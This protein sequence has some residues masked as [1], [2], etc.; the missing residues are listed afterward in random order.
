MKALIADC[1]T[2]G[3][4]PNRTM[5]L[6]LQPSII[7][8]VA[9]T[10]DLETGAVENELDLLIKPPKPIDNDIT[11]ITSI[12]NAMLEGQPTFQEAAPQIKERI[13]SAQLVIAHNASFDVEMVEIEMER[14][15]LKVNW[16]RVLCTVEQTVGIKG[17]R[18]TLSALHG[19]LFGTTFSG[20]HRARADVEALARCCCELFKRGMI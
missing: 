17:F 19:E 11:R 7:E 18:L 5:K 13:E 6:E 8:F 2:S 1:E 12:T 14:C 3:L 15:G 10:V 16:P 20:A 4:I 9:L